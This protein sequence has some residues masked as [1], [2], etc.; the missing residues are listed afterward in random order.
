MNKFLALMIFFF[1]AACQKDKADVFVRIQNSSATQFSDINVANVNYGSIPPSITS[2]YKLIT[3][4]IY[5]P[6]CAATISDS[7]F[8]IGYGVCGTPLPSS[9]K[10][11]KYTYVIK[12]SA[13]SVGY[14][15]IEVKKD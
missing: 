1:S 7:S 10:G 15:D 14:Y 3:E 9:F 4:P 11:G 13:S 2:D 6:L 12:P 8:Y 5:A